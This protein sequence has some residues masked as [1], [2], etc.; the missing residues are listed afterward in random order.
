MFFA[1]F[2]GLADGLA[3]CIAGGHFFAYLV[4]EDAV[5]LEVVAFL[6]E[7]AVLGVVDIEHRDD[8]LQGIAIFLESIR[9]THSPFGRSIVLAVVE[10]VEMR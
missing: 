3:Q 6:Q 10:H 8:K 5:A 7:L 2:D 4:D 1:V 9:E